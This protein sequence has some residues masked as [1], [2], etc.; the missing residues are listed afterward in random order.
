MTSCVFAGEERARESSTY[1]RQA[2]GQYISGW[3]R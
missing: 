2:V 3:S 1:L